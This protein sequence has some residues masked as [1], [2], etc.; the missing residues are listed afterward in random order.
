MLLLNYWRGET[1]TVEELS[2]TLAITHNLTINEDSILQTLY[3]WPE[4]YNISWVNRGGLKLA[5][6]LPEAGKE[7]LFHVKVDKN[8]KS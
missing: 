3:L 2:R 4:A 1:G 5:I 6:T 7:S 8:E